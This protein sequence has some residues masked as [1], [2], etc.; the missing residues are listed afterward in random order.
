MLKKGKPQQ[1][2]LPGADPQ[3]D[4]QSPEGAPSEFIP[5][6]PAEE[7]LWDDD[8]DH[9]LSWHEI[10]IDGYE[11]RETIA[12]WIPQ[13]AAW[14]IFMERIALA[15]E[16]PANRL[17]GTAQLNPFY[18]TGTIATLLL[19]IVALTGFFLFLFFQY[20]FDAS[21]NAV[22]T[23]IETPFIART[24]RAI[25]RY[26]SGALVITTLLHA[27]RTLFMERFRGPRWLA[28]VTGIVMTALLWFAGVTG[29]W[30]I[31]DQRSQLIN[32]AF[33]DFLQTLTP[34]AASYMVTITEAASS[35]NSWYIFLAIFAVHVLL[36]LIVA[37]FYWYHIKRLS[38]PKWL[39]PV[40]WVVGV[41][42]V[43]VL[44]SLLFPA[45]MLPQGNLTQLPGLVTID[46]IFL[47]YLPAREYPS[48]NWLLWGG[49]VFFT[50]A[51]SLLPWTRRRLRESEPALDLEQ[52]FP[53]G[54]PVVNII[55]DRCSGCTVCALDC[56]Y[57]AIEMVERNDGKRHKYIAIEDPGLCVSC[58]IC[59]GSCDGVAVTMGNTPPSAL[60]DTISLQLAFAKLKSPIDELQVVF[61]CE[62][63]A[64]HGARP[65][66]ERSAENENG[67][68]IEVIELPCV[69]SAPPDLLARTLDEGV[70]NVHII[71]CPAD[72]CTNREGNI[73]LEQRITRERLPRLKRQY[74]DAP[75]TASWLPPDDFNLGI[76]SIP[77]VGKEREDGEA[78]AVDYM[79]LRQMY[80]DLTWRNY[81][82]AFLLLAF[83]MVVQ[84]LLTDLAFSPYQD[85]DAAGQVVISDL[86]AP[87]GRTSYISS[88]LGPSL[89]LELEVNG[90]VVVED[91]VQ[92]STVLDNDTYPYFEE[93]DL[94]V[95]N[96]QL[97]LTLTDPAT[98]TSFIYFN[99]PVVV[100]EGDILTIPPPSN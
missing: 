28:W 61:T 19:I 49:L 73:W 84:V 10:D 70:A 69:G 35:G 16:K 20:G 93:F 1:N 83:V 85:K 44:V 58:G 96:H 41:G 46:P 25:H 54:Q 39:P 89:Y 78:A 34:F 38:R 33:V 8:H 29:Y 40:F 57:G 74:A 60:W 87:I 80:R 3:A 65:Y 82:V 45:G 68:M 6:S 91:T 43:V 24:V 32:D 67:K 59:V 55:K 36:T 64:V 63:H 53:P 81:L 62:R 30:L 21:Y 75:I 31:W 11:Q 5:L 77:P 23:R 27:Y 72:D 26:A 7:T 97:R 13:R 52:P 94:S 66:I 4:C 88:T 56:P 76:A 92:T 50:V 22:L 48:I 15:V 37:A 18:H 95:G 86:A 42:V 14:S 90:E 98:A 17:I 51:I 79:A 71:G 99:A 100:S 47:Y 12:S 2:L 9:D